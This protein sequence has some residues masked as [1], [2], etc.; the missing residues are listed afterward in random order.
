M[1]EQRARELIA[2]VQPQSARRIV[3]YFSSEFDSL[4]AQVWAFGLAEGPRRALAIIS[5]MGAEL[6][7]GASALYSSGRW[8]AGAALV[9]QLIEVE[10]LMFLFAADSEEAERWLRAS[11]DDVKRMFSPAVMRDRAGDRFRTE[12]YFT[13]CEIGGH[14]RRQGAH[15][16]QEHDDQ[17]HPPVDVQWVDLA[18]HLERLWT[19]YK[20]AVSK[21]SPTNVYAQRFEDIDHAFEAWRKTDPV[22]GAI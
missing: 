10:Y 9:R 7:L 4:S 13:H 16:L 11:P 15:L 6:A 22:P 21:L 19:H 8:Y 18:Q 12:E 17:R 14:P 5:Q 3:E 2:S 20:I 1:D